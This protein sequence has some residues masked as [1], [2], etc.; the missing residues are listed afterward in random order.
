MRA[1]VEAIRNGKVKQDRIWKDRK[2][3]KD[4]LRGCMADRIRLTID[5]KSAADMVAL[6]EWCNMSHLCF[7]K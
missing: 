1:R 6:I 5:L 7:K 4:S 2:A 3:F